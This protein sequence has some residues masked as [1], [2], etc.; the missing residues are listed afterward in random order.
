LLVC[1]ARTRRTSSNL[2]S[3][4]PGTPLKRQTGRFRRCV[5]HPGWGDADPR[6]RRPAR[7]AARAR[8]AFIQGGTSKCEGIARR[9]TVD[10]D[11]SQDFGLVMTVFGRALRRC[12]HESSPFHL[13]KNSTGTTRNQASRACSWRL[14]VFVTCLLLIISILIGATGFEPV[15][16]SIPSISAANSLFGLNRVPSSVLLGFRGI[17][18]GYN[19]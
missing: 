3:G 12:G 5:R 2:L 4:S 16:S 7:G 8:S 9:P 13:G 15:T 19:A 6:A 10:A 18:R 1:S 14:M 11:P 17:A